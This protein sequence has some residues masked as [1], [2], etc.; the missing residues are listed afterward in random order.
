MNSIRFGFTVVCQYDDGFREEEGL[1]FF[2]KC[3]PD[4]GTK[5]QLCDKKEWTVVEID[6]FRN[7]VICELSKVKK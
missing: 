6:A 3:P 5:V 1:V 4:I 7:E 2:D